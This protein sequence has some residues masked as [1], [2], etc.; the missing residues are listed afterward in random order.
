MFTILFLDTV[1][2]PGFKP[3]TVIKSEMPS[4][5]ACRV[6]DIDLDGDLDIV[7]G[8]QTAGTVVLFRN[9][10]GEYIPETLYTGSEKITILE[11]GLINDD[12][13][14][15][16]LIAGTPSAF[17]LRDAH[18]RALLSNNDGSYSVFTFPPTFREYVDLC[19]ADCN[20]DGKD[21]VIASVDY[22]FGDFGILYFINKDDGK[23]E[24]VD[25]L[26]KSSNRYSYFDCVDLDRD[27]KADII[28]CNNNNNKLVK[29]SFNS[30]SGKLTGTTLDSLS[31]TSNFQLIDLN[32]DS[33][34]DI[35]ISRAYILINNGDNTFSVPEYMSVNIALGEIGAAV[36]LTG[37]SLADYLVSNSTDRLLLLFTKQGPEGGLLKDTISTQA[38]LIK[39]IVPAD[40]DNDGDIDFVV[41]STG[42]STVAV[43]T[44]D[45]NNKFS[46]KKLCA[47]G[48]PYPYHAISVDFDKNGTMDLVVSSSA[49]DR[50]TLF[51]NNG[52]ESFTPTI[53]YTDFFSAATLTAADIDMDGDVDI[54]AG[55]DE[56]M[57][58]T[59]GW[60][61]NGNTDGVS[62]Q[63]I[64]STDS[65]CNNPIAVDLDN[66]GDLDILGGSTFGGV[67][68]FE[69]SGDGTFS[70]LKEIADISLINQVWAC[71]LDRDGFMDAVS[72]GG[73]ASENC[74]VRFH[75]NNGAGGFDK[76]L[77]LV[78]S[79]SSNYVWPGD[80]D[81]DGNSE[82]LTFN[83]SYDLLMLSWNG[84][85]CDTKALFP[86]FGMKHTLVVADLDN[87]NDSDVVWIDD[88]C[89]TLGWLEN[90]GELSFVNHTL[91]GNLPGINSV[92]VGDI[93]GDGDRDLLTTNVDDGSLV[94]FEN[95]PGGIR[96][97]DRQV[98]N[99]IQRVS[100]NVKNRT[101]LQLS[102]D[103]PSETT[104]KVS[105]YNTAGQRIALI[106]NR[107]FSSGRSTI[108]YDLSRSNASGMFIVSMECA[109]IRQTESVVVH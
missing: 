68:W 97:I 102:F 75:R 66:D 107:K 100:V 52:K 61:R 73:G 36:D 88:S 47:P 76:P 70:S 87:D 27:G 24:T 33:Y 49:D 74:E 103:L 55:S 8:S 54:L 5:V 46:V 69:N 84:G 53:L 6:V 80:I 11:T 10:G 59:L 77:T 92:S 56:F 93:D 42:E 81:G 15:D 79:T 90:R 78:G 62:F 48:L 4:P 44:N 39:N 9:S 22:D 2:L 85:G 19:V 89:K 94:W 16:L 34:L 32:N 108:A 101:I 12:S 25:T 64:K 21:D 58:N 14:P 29:Y 38:K 86:K 95:T 72:Y 26:E 23:F 67:Y 83:S 50:I 28:S 35:F 51:S 60:I 40:M 82:I 91:A 109:G 30:D 57:K 63:S 98:P 37:D 31:I 20:N 13:I 96:T 99:M 41:T 104:V 7:S 1:T 105:L 106:A 17:Y 71:D 65:E 43:Y 3:H 45:G 18:L